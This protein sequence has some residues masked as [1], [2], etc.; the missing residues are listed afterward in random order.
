MKRLLILMIRLLIACL[1]FPQAGPV[2][3]FAKTQEPIK[4]TPLTKRKD[5]GAVKMFSLMDDGAMGIRFVGK[6]LTKEKLED[7]NYASSLSKEPSAHGVCAGDYDGDGKPDLFFSHPYGGHQLFRN[8]GN[9]RFEEVTKKA[10]ITKVVGNHWAMGCCFVDHDGDGDLDLFVGGSGDPALLFDNQGDGTFKEKGTALGLP[11][12]GSNVQMAFADYDLDGD[13]DG[14]LVTNRDPG[15]SSRT[16]NLSI[17]AKFVNGEPVIE[18]KYRGVFDAIRHPTEGLHF[19]MAGEEDRLFQYDGTKYHDVSQT[20]GLKGT[21]MGLA[22]SWFDYDDDGR[23]DLYLAN[24]FFGPDRLYRNLGNGS[25]ADVAKAV[26]PHVPWFSMGTDVADVNNDGMLDF[27]GSDMAGSDHYKSK[28]GMG[29]MEQ[30]G[31]FLKTSNPSQYMR[32]ALFLNAGQGRFLEAAHLAGLASTDWTWSLKFADLD[33]DGWIDLFGTN[34]MT[35]DTSNSDLQAKANALET[36]REAGLFWW[37]TPPKR[38]HN[39][40]F[41]NLGD[42]KFKPIASEWGLDFNGVSYGAALADFDGDGDLDLAIASLEDPIRIYRNESH[43]GHRV[44]IRLKGGKRNSH[45]IGA[46]V[47]LET[48]NGMQTRYLTSCQG[49]AS[50]NEP[51]IHFGLGASK[52]IK[53]LT[54]RWPLGA[55]QTFQNLPADQYLVITEPKEAQAAPR[56]PKDKSWFVASDALGM[57]THQENDF[58]DFKVQP[59]LPHQ[60]SKLGPGMAWAD[61]DGDGDEDVFFGGASGHGSNLAVNKGDGSFALSPQIDLS[62][63]QM[64]VFED[65]GAVFLD[66]DS[67]GDL[68][69]YVAS[70]G[71]DPRPNP[72]YLRDRLYLNDGKGNFR[73]DLHA[74]SDLRDSGGPVASA[75]FDR[76]GDL[77]LFVGGRVMKARYPTTP[78]SRLLRN[79]G[80]KFTDVSDELA[81]GLR[82]TGMVT[83]AIWSD[84]N[85]DGWLDLM[86]T[87]EWGPVAMW[88]NNKGKL[89]NASEQAGTSDRLGWWTGIEAADLDGDG[90]MDYVVGNMGLNTKYHASKEKP[91]LLYFGDLDGSGTPRIVEACHEGGVLFPVRGKSCSTRAMP[92]LGKKFTSFHAFASATLPQIYAPQNLQAAQRLVINELSSGILLNDGKG[93]LTFRPLPRLAQVSAVFGLAFHDWDA[94]GHTDLAVAHNFYS[95]Q[96]ETGNFDGGLGM[97]L[98]GLGNGNFKPMSADQ[99]GFLLPGDAKALALTDLDGDARPDLVATVN[100]DSPRTFLNQTSK[101]KG[102]AIRLQGSPGN[103]RGIGSRVTLHL[104]SGRTLVGEVHSGS[105]YLT[106]SS[107][108]IFFSIPEEDEAG[109][110]TIRSPIGQTTRHP[111]KKLTGTIT[112]KLAN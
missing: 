69:L 40:A 83:G 29:E 67:D 91:Y 42:L 106:G 92:S 26:L 16:N 94:D 58:D 66:A 45:A 109:S 13:L 31:W 65:M 34:G 52:V 78:N 10:G 30:F 68:D 60:L 48:A 21:D 4:M 47:T 77:D 36:D 53:R 112:V 6:S 27:M 32:N 8:L 86:V 79:D 96:P 18:E 100:S 3:L 107:T 25:F 73:I 35:H 46:K 55:V 76:D 11:K 102:L 82:Q 7:M 37:N 54:I 63:P 71:F 89:T 74:T 38:D 61:V 20:A 1:L 28:L 50:A 72:V 41:R 104:K 98:K 81:P 108:A 5:T 80:G 24:D 22:A 19:V 43:Q 49:Y 97:M 85:G 12:T 101:A 59:L 75:D 70:G 103:M 84:C 62:H 9:W 64:N 44:K 99:S 95:P 93:R 14:F 90:D 88:K 87:H 111:L 2:A 15:T 39:F 56:N 105:S 57:V 23:P 17:Q 110:L 33:N 51:I